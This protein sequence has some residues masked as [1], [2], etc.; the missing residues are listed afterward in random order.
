MHFLGKGVRKRLTQPMSGESGSA[1]LR[2]RVEVRGTDGK[3]A[4]RTELGDGSD[5]RGLR[6][7]RWKL[8]KNGHA[9]PLLPR[10]WE[11]AGSHDADPKC[12]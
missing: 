5:S 10:D 12:L 9:A 7:R 2:E 4:V 11:Q 3:A 6:S 1:L 8:L